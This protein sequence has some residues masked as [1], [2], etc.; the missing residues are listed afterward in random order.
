L[1]RSTR[2]LSS[3][4]ILPILLTKFSGPTH[5]AFRTAYQIRILSG[6]SSRRCIGLIVLLSSQFR[7]RRRGFTSARFRI[8]YSAIPILKPIL[9]EDEWQTQGASVS[10]LLVH[11]RL[12]Y[13]G[14]VIVCCTGS[15]LFMTTTVIVR[16][17]ILGCRVFAEKTESPA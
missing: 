17:A 4:M 8:L 1:L 3:T 10:W 16:W 14:D 7:L 6:F 5:S 9:R 13:R 11:F 15:K 12:L 2:L